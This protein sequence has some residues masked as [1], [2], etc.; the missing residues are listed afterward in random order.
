[1]A[2]QRPGGPSAESGDDSDVLLAVFTCNRLGMR[3][4]TP[5][6]SPRPGLRFGHRRGRRAG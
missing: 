4:T 6:T 3:A 1:M 2:T 5:A